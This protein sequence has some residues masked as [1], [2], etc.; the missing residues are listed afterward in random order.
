MLFKPLG[1]LH[2]VGAIGYIKSGLIQFSTQGFCYSGAQTPGN[3]TI[4]ICGRWFVSIV[5]CSCISSCLVLYTVI[6]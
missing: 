3:E 1:K 5:A 2:V 6:L 4:G